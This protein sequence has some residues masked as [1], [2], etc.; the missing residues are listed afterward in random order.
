[1]NMAPE[2]ERYTGPGVFRDRENPR[3]PGNTAAFIHVDPPRRQRRENHALTKGTQIPAAASNATATQTSQ[4]SQRIRKQQPG[5]GQRAQLR[6]P[7]QR[8]VAFAAAAAESDVEQAASWPQRES[9][10]EVVI[11]VGLSGQ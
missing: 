6:T 3:I 2:A 10:I 1:M 11:R 4:S 9:S 8:Y 5:S 7:G